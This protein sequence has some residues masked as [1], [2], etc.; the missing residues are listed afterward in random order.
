MSGVEI[1]VITITLGILFL[2]NIWAFKEEIKGTYFRHNLPKLPTIKT[3]ITGKNPKVI[4]PGEI[5]YY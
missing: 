3:D 4:Y 1:A 2:I 5:G